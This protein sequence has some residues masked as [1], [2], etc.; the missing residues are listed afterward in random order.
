MNRIT[1]AAI[2]ACS[3]AAT[4]LPASVLAAEPQGPRQLPLTFG[5]CVSGS[6]VIEGNPAPGQTGIAPG[7]ALID[8]ETGDANKN[9]GPLNPEQFIFGVAC[10]RDVGHRP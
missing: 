8:L 9:V 3:V 4:L 7:V 6:G 5:L 2:G 10:G 1:K